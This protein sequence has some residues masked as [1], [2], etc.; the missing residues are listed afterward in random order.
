MIA[1]RPDKAFWLPLSGEIGRAK[2]LHSPNSFQETFV[3]QTATARPPR[4]PLL[5]S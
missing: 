3:W 4:R 2:R 1:T 5:R